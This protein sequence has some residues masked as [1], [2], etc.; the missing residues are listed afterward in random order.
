MTKRR[1][2]DCEKERSKCRDLRDTLSNQSNT[3]FVFA[4]GKEMLTVDDRAQSLYNPE[5]QY[6]IYTCRNVL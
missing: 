4:D 5:H 3:C 1:L 6:V 2:V